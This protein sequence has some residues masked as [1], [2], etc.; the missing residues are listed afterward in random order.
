MGHHEVILRAYD[1]PTLIEYSTHP[2]ALGEAVL[3][4]TPSGICGLHFLDQPLAHYL[5]LAVRRWGT[6]PVPASALDV[7]WWSR[8][9][10]QVPT[11]LPLVV[12]G[13]PFQQQVW[14][15]LCALP[16]GTTC[17]YQDLATQL[18]RPNGARAVGNAVASNL[19]AWLIPCHRVVRQ[20]G[21]L[22]GYRWGVARKR[23]LLEAEKADGGQQILEL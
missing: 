15:A 1:A 12:Q 19:I 9:Q 3:L 14:R 16:V 7:P 20:D 22:S 23:A 21:H 11:T 17:T 10:Q 2:T 6:T 13:T 4:T 18:G 5:Q 8:I